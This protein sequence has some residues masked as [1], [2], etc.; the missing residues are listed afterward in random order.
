MTRLHE[1][2]DYLLYRIY[3]FGGFALLVVYFGLLAYLEA[4]EVIRLPRTGGPELFT[5]FVA[6]VNVWVLGILAYWWWVFLFKGSRERREALRDRPKDVPPLSALKNWSTLQT[7][8]AIYGGDADEIL[9]A[10]KAGRRPVLIFYG[11]QNLLVLWIFAN[12]WIWLY[13]EDVLPANYTTAIMAPGVVVIAIFGF[14]ITPLLV[15]RSLRSGEAA[16]LAPLGLAVAQPH[17]DQPY[18]S[19]LLS[20]GQALTGE[21]ATVLFG[22]RRGRPVHVETKGKRSQTLVQAEMPPFRIHSQAGKL[23]TGEGAPEAVTRALKGMR[24]AKRWRGIEVVG[25]P[26]GVRVQRE[27]PG[28]NMWLYDLWLAERL[29]EESIRDSSDSTNRAR[30]SRESSGT[31]MGA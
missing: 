27:S 26:G 15:G 14:V 21:G 18:V 6:P 10:E 31:R 16:Y 11:M 17:S 22:S 20:M 28:Q 8:M 29:L 2:L 23:V 3:V 4:R 30:S 13:F 24:K 7:A 1:G 5:P 9:K 19:G 25:G 12:F